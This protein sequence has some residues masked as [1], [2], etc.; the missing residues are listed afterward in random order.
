MSPETYCMTVEDMQDL[1]AV[2]NESVTLDDI[3]AFTSAS[4]VDVVYERRGL[5]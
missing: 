5:E 2:Y 4:T 1:L 3:K